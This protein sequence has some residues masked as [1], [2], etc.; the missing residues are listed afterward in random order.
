MTKLALVNAQTNIVENISMDDRPASEIAI[1][2]YI[3]LDL[4]AV[5]GGSI[6]S[7]WNG[8]ALVQTQS[9]VVPAVVSPRQARLALHQANLL[10][11]VETVIAAADKGTQL[12]WEYA[13]EFRRNDALVNGLGQQIG[14][15]SGQIDQL[16]ITASTL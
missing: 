14:L 7:V 13:I 10:D 12:A 16:F 9:V 2:G 5:G 3:V 15:T 4:D 11:E 1:P 6:G 8:T